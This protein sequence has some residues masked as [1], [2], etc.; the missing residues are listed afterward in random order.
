MILMIAATLKCVPHWKIV[1]Y[2]FRQCRRHRHCGS[3]GGSDVVAAWYWRG[4]Y[5]G[6]V[7]AVV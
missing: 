1:G 5:S 3:C 6:M 4:D 7:V 2:D